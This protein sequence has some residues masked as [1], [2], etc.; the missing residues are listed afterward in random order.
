[1]QFSPHKPHNVPERFAASVAKVC[2]TAYHVG[3][4]DNWRILPYRGV[5]K[6]IEPFVGVDYSKI[7][8]SR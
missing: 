4:H 3:D 5:R 7:S 6:G 2:T 8:S 1:M